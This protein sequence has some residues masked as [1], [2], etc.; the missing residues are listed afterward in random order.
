[1]YY[2]VL[3]LHF[4]IVLELVDNV[5]VAQILYDSEHEL[6]L[7]MPGLGFVT[8]LSLARVHMRRGD[9]LKKNNDLSPVTR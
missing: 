3:T 8:T 2:K 5:E 9:I 4:T 6:L 1:M 7:W